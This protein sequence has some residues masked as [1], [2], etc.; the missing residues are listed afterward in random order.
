MVARV[1]MQ[2]VIAATR[3]V[4]ATRAL[5]GWLAKHDGAADPQIA[6]AMALQR[7]LRFPPLEALPLDAGRR[8]AR[9]RIALLDLDPEPMAQVIDTQ[10]GGVPTRVYVPHGATGDWL[11]YFHGGGGVIGSIESYE[12]TT[13]YLAANTGCTVASVEY[14]LAPE[15]AH[16]AAIDDANA[17]FAALAARVPAGKRLV[18]GGDSFG[19]FL[20]AHVER[21]ARRAGGRRPDLQVLVYPLV[22]LT[23]RSQGS[24]DGPDY[25]LTRGMVDWFY[26]SYV[27]SLPD[28]KAASPLFWPDVA[29]TAPAIIAAAALDPLANEIRAWAD[30]LEGAGT[31]VRYVCHASLVHGFVQIA[32]AVAAAR[33]AF[34]AICDEIRAFVDTPGSPPSR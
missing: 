12:A 6:A 25:L 18:V 17:A 5:V 4:L 26:T 30:R 32:G 27:R 8:A 21:H 22:D 3:R 1:R 29:G 13:R 33:A 31:P 23:M 20:T 24:W 15:H 19:G 7:V 10:A 11:V 16:P 14:R 2:L 28:P 9:Q 34:D